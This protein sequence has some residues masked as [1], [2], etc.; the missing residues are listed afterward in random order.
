MA[1]L[2]PWTTGTTLPSFADSATD[3]SRLF[4]PATRQR[5]AGVKRRYDPANV[6]CTSFPV[7]A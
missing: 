3:P 2:S 4:T 1:A 6:F 5:L 7:T